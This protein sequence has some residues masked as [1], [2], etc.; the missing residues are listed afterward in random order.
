MLKEVKEDKELQERDLQDRELQDRKKERFIILQHASSN[1]TKKFK[2]WWLQE[3]Y[4]FRFDADGSHFNVYVSDEKC[5]EEIDL[6]NRST[7][8]Q[9]F[10]SFYLTFITQEQKYNNTIILLDE[11]GLTLH[12]LAQKNLSAFLKKLSEKYQLFY[13]THSP[14]LIDAE[15]LDQLNKVYRNNNGYTVATSNLREGAQQ[16]RGASYAVYSALNL[17][18]SESL[19]LGC[20]VVLV[21]GVS[22]QFYLSAIKNFLIKEG[23]IQPSKELVFPPCGGCQT[24]KPVVSILLG[25]DEIYP[26]VILDGDKQGEGAKKSLKEFYKGNEDKIISLNEVVINIDSPEVEDLFPKEIMFKELEK[27]LDKRIAYDLYLN[28][29]KS[30][31]TQVIEWG[32][33]KE[34][35]LPSDWKILLSKSILKSS[36]E[37]ENF[38][39]S[40]DIIE[41]WVKIFKKI[42]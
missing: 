38:N 5:Q 1:L 40:Q 35:K 18:V 22:D 34:E 26:Y 17:N 9:F 7:G 30:F 42:K 21:E 28:E 11:P 4:R 19:L 10:L 36:F 27:I 16:D 37:Q 24:I 41:I 15:R 8:L 33:K 20:Q 6:E 13:T 14:F 32:K 31:V 3:N 29:R 23:H 25:R 39:I 12:P 2:E